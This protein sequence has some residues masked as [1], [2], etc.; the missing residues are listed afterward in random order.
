MDGT[1][2][3]TRIPTA[4]A[5]QHSLNSVD[6]DSPYNIGN[7]L[8]HFTGKPI[9]SIYESLLPESKWGK[10][11][12]LVN[13]ARERFEETF[14]E[15]SEI[16]PNVKETLPELHEK[17]PQLF[18]ATVK[19]RDYADRLLSHHG[20]REYFSDVEGSILDAPR[21]L[22]KSEVLGIL[23]RKHNL[24]A[25]KGR[26]VGDTISDIKAGKDC[27]LFT[28]GVSYGD[29]LETEQERAEADKIINNFSELLDLD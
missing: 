29:G 23:F 16:Y 24:D 6:S 26:I 22:V 13:M 21:E 10:I 17:C 14:L 18:V 8:P 4:E 19:P 9:E 15:K 7:I 12:G 28:I 5:I 20:I 1:M 11:G 3:D 25:S 27:G 2:L